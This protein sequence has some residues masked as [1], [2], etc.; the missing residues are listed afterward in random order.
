MHLELHP[1][2]GF[3]VI[4]DNLNLPGGLIGANFRLEDLL[5]DMQTI[6]NFLKLSHWLANDMLWVL[7]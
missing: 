2:S 1:D 4:L 7:W 3:N 5:S 6:L